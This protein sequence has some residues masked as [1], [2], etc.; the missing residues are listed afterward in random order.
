MGKMK[1]KKTTRRF[2]RSATFLGI[3]LA[4]TPTFAESPTSENDVPKAPVWILN[5]GPDG[6]DA[7]VGGADLRVETGLTTMN[8]VGTDATFSLPIDEKNRFAAAE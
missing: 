6:A 8:V 2:F 5:N 4:V 7:T 1:Q 3:A